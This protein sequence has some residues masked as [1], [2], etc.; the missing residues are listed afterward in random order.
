VLDLTNSSYTALPDGRSVRV[1]GSTFTQ[2]TPE[3]RWT[4]KLEGAKVE[5]YHSIF[6]GGCADPIL[7]S[8][9]D[10]LLVRVRA[11]VASKCSFEYDL[12]LTVYGHEGA[13]NMLGTRKNLGPTRVS[14]L[15]QPPPVTVGILGQA[16]AATQK[17]ANMV[18]AMA[19]V[20]CVHGPYK[21]Q[22][23]YVSSA[24]S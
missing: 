20:A 24:R 9:L 15:R 16:R 5:G 17:E 22:K 21:G 1:Q 7:I 13:L 8:Q 14:P 12:K 19:R 3:S 6:I 11:Y 10:D 4:V 23:A 2:S 18:V